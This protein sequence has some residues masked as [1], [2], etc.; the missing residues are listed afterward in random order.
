MSGMQLTHGLAIQFEQ[1][2]QHAVRG[3]MLRSHVQQ[4]GF[5]LDGPVRD[6]VF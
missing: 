4:H 1:Q 6:Q 2:A 3:G 5:A